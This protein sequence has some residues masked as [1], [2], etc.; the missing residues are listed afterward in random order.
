MTVHQ[1]TDATFDEAVQ[2]ADRPVL[3]E[4][5][6]AWC[7][8]CRQLEPILDE[9]AAERADDLVVASL[10]TD[11]NLEVPRRLGVMSLPTMVLFVDGE[12]RA[13]LVGAR[14]KGRLLEDLGPHLPRPALG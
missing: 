8:P 5:T 9:L 4:L 10:D 14:G 7:P 6:A 3:V 2:G 12:E 13:R 11:A 1:L